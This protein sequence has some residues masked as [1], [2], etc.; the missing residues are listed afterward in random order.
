MKHLSRRGLGSKALAIILIVIIIAGV[1]GY[2]FTAHKGKKKVGPGED[3]I[4]VGFTAPLTG[5]YRDVGQAF[6]NGLKLWAS[7][8]NSQGGIVINGKSYNIYLKYY[9]DKG[10]PK[11]TAKLYKKLIEEDYADFLITPPLGDC[12]LQA[13]NVAEGHGKIIID[14][15][16]GD[17][18]FQTGL[19]YTYQIATPASKIFTPVLDLAKSLDPN[20][21]K[22]AIIAIDTPESRGIAS[23]V[24]VWAGTNNYQIVFE[25]YY[26]PGTK[27]FDSIAR[28]VAQKSPDIIIGGGGIE[29]T[30]NLV[31]AL[32]N[33]GVRPK[34]IALMGGPL[35]EEFANLGSLAVGV[36]GVGEW[37]SVATYSPFQA[38]K[39][40][41]TWYG[42]GVTEFTVSYEKAYGIPP[43][44]TAASAYAAGLVLQYA[45]EKA[46]SLS[47]ADIEQVLD[48]VRLL[49][50]YGLIQ[51]DNTPEL[52][53]LQI[54]HEPVVVQWMLRG[55]NMVK[56]VVAP[57]EFAVAKPIYPLPWK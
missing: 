39:L 35:T 31:K 13:I 20:S 10:D 56:L 41:A 3:V 49:T 36:M 37:E 19:K 15:T 21:T 14:V 54:A 9:D 28:I 23:G 32:Y 5:P 40:N 18:I 6:L 27:N 33:A 42:P 12:A 7:K 48:H 1:A 44:S 17:Q 16:S 45:L 57:K 52:H 50:F 30:I 22:I 47:S 8:V 25:Y 4:T 34:L 53:G 51:F 2:Y 24:K 46:Q 29:E 55:G 38:K 11:E 43:T 26:A